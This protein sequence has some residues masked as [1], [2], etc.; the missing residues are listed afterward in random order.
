METTKSGEP[1]V[2]LH[3]W[4]NEI[5]VAKALQSYGKKQS[6]PVPCI[7]LT[8]NFLL[9]ATF[10]CPFR[11]QLQPKEQTTDET[12][13]PAQANFSNLFLGWD[14]LVVSAQA[15]RI[16]IQ[17]G[18]L[19]AIG[20]H[21]QPEATQGAEATA[22]TGIGHSESTVLDPATQKELNQALEALRAEEPAKAAATRGRQ[23]HAVHIYPISRHS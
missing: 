20:P 22:D 7:R 1:R 15:Y 18:K 12:V 2:S 5:S 16:L 21:Q 3:E 9:V 23:M 17:P 11:V 14:E 8:T 6:M 13:I 19:T 4:W 10:L